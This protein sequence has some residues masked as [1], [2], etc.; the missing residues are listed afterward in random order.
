M[1]SIIQN[2]E[3][4][5]R[6]DLLSF[7]VENIDTA[8]SIIKWTLY[9]KWLGAPDESYI[10]TIKSNGL[11]NTKIPDISD[12]FDRTVIFEGSI[13]ETN[14]YY[15]LGVKL[16]ADIITQHTTIDSETNEEIITYSTHVVE[17]TINAIIDNDIIVAPSNMRIVYKTLKCAP[18]LT[19]HSFKAFYTGDETDNIIASYLLIS[20]DNNKTFKCISGF[21]GTIEAQHTWKTTNK[22]YLVYNILYDDGFRVKNAEISIEFAVNDYEIRDSDD[23]SCVIDNMHHSH[24]H[25]DTPPKVYVICTKR[26]ITGITKEYSMPGVYGIED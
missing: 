26:C 6:H 4:T 7:E 19:T 25:G 24:D 5:S 10:P 21:D 14:I 9:D 2:K 23:P 11:L 15:P 8:N 18:L 13:F 17:T 20:E 22:K 12:Y 16:R 3:L 1:P